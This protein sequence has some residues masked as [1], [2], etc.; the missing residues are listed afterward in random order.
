MQVALLSCRCAHTAWPLPMAQGV[1]TLPGARSWRPIGWD[2]AKGELINLIES[3]F[4]F[5][6]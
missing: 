3:S 2:L 5:Y 6:N 4:T 1:Q